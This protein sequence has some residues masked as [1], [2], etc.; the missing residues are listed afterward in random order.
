MSSDKLRA[1]ALHPSAAVERAAAALVA[2]FDGPP[3]RVW[4]PDA[5]GRRAGAEWRA[6]GQ[7]GGAAVTREQAQA[8]ALRAYGLLEARRLARR[9]GADA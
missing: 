4:T 8:A 3:A 6:R 7:I 2:Y 9:D 5:I 1:M